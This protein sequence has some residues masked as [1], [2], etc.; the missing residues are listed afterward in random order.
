[1]VAYCRV[2]P[3][4]RVEESRQHEN[5]SPCL[6]G[7]DGSAFTGGD[8]RVYQLGQPTATVGCQP[9][10]TCIASCASLSGG[11]AGG[12]PPGRW[13]ASSRVPASAGWVSPTVQ[14]CSAWS[15]WLVGQ[16]T[17]SDGTPFLPLGAS[18]CRECWPVGLII[19]QVAFE[20]LCAL[21]VD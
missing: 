15:W 1:M 17:W 20:I 11:V 2:D 10:F 18:S 13:H 8:S 12:W 4:C 16:S 5:E 6:W 3:N 7:W 9:D 21:P 14:T 19:G